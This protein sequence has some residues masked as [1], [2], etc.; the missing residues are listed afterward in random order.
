[1]DTGIQTVEN[2]DPSR[3]KGI[4]GRVAQPCARPTGKRG[5]PKK[6]RPASPDLARELTVTINHFFPELK[7]WLGEL[8]D[9]RNP[10]YIVYELKLLLLLGILMFLTHSGSR[11][12]FNDR[13]RD[14]GELAR[15]LAR[16]LESPVEALPH[17]DTLEKV[18]RRLDSTRIENLH[19][20]LLRRLIRMKALDDWRVQ[21]RFL[22]AADGTGVYSFSKRHCDHCIET[23]HSSG[24]IVYSHKVLVAFIV[25]QTGYALPIACQFIENPGPV[26]DKQDCEKKA[27][28]RLRASL[29][30]HFPQTPFWF[31]L[32]ALYADQNVMKPCVANRWNFCISFLETDMP[33]LWAE[34][35]ALLK[36]AP[37]QCAKITL[38]DGEGTR[39]VRWINDMDYAGMKLSA[40]YQVDRDQNGD[41]ICQFAHLVNT[42]KPI[43][44]DNV[45]RIAGTARLRWRC[46]NE[47]FN[48]L[49][50][51]GFGLEH[52][53][54]RHP[55]AAKVYFF[56]MLMAHIIQQLLTRG[57]L[58][59]V[60]RAAFHTCRNYGRRL[61][62]ALCL[63]PLPANLDM[64]GQIRLSYA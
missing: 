43:N 55:Q 38:P 50:N 31:L 56:M 39:E 18:L 54:S 23:K 9:P 4:H 42:D 28:H 46:E 7:N 32:D 40:I 58:G 29:Q 30:Q 17:L 64:P 20:L 61:M 44:A 48:V 57:R 8:P 21:G 59:A 63:N 16:L 1:M 3:D 19:A 22:L 11:N 53:Y 25:S 5:R 15:T 13:L 24:A 35:Q 6:E 60:F 10:L 41:I 12:H 47:G 36:L 27:F 33:A 49:K 45:W 52:V 34:G 14:A 37:G 2:A 51:G 26:Y 62:E